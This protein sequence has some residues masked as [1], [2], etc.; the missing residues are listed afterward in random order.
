MTRFGISTGTRGARHGA[1]PGT[2]KAFVLENSPLPSV[3]PPGGDIHLMPQSSVRLSRTDEGTNGGRGR[4]REPLFV[5]PAEG[6]AWVA[7]QAAHLLS[8]F[9]ICG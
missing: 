2:I 1:E 6:R 3:I 8:W 9:R 7:Q 5:P 4:R